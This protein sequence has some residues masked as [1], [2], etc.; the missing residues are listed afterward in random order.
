MEKATLFRGCYDWQEPGKKKNA[1]KGRGSRK[2][3]KKTVI[4]SIYNERDILIENSERSSFLV[5]LSFAFVDEK[6]L[7][8]GMPYYPGGSLK[9]MLDKQPL[10]RFREADV[11]W[12]A[13]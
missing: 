11:K 6:F 13:A 5:H 3:S 10:H 4:N 2:K 8:L 7:Y 12:Y 1:S 9:E